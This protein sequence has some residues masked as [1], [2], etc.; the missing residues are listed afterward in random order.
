[1]SVTEEQLAEV[2]RF[3]VSE[4][5]KLDGLQPDW[6]RTGYGDFQMTWP[7]IDG[8]ITL[9]K[10]KFRLPTD[11]FTFPSISLIHRNHMISRFD[12]VSASECEPNPPYAQRFGLPARVC[13]PHVHS[14]SHNRPHVALSGMWALPAREP[15]A[16]N[17]NHL[18]QMF[19][20]FCEHT[21]IVI[22]QENRGIYLPDADLFGG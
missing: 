18:K 7:V 1:M 11:N 6:I 10:L 9:A 19:Y 22:P 8:E 17:I 21:K 14:W 5:K 2:D 15:V 4:S 3:L 13:G 16:D 12:K 20:W